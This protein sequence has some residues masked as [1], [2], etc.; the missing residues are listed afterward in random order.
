M[1]G[2]RRRVP[3]GAVIF[4]VMLGLFLGAMESTAVATAMP[5]VIASLG[6]LAI[7]SWVFSGYI[8]AATISMPL[9]GKAADLYGRRAAYLTG[10]GIFLGGSILSGFATSMAMLIGF[11]TLQGLGG[12][13]LIQLG[14]TIIADLYGLERR[15]KMQG[16]FS[17][18]WGIAS[19][20]GP[21]IGG[22]LTDQL[23]WRWVFFVNVPFGLLAA[24]ILGWALAGLGRSAATVAVDVRGVALLTAGMAALLGALVEGGRSGSFGLG[25]VALFVVAAAFLTAFVL[26]ERRAPEPLLPLRLFANR[27]FRAAAVS[28]FLAGMAMFGTISFIPLFVQGVLGGTATEAGT[29]L[30]P[31]VLGWVTLSVISARLLLKVGYRWPVLSG[32]ICLA[33]AF[34]LMSHMGLGTSRSA[35]GRN[36]LLAGMGMGLI[37]VP[38]LIAVQNA[39]PKRDL[40]AATSGTTFFR[41][42]G[43]AVGVA[44]MGAVLSHQLAS[45]LVR[46]GGAADPVSGPQLQ[47]LIAHP[48]AVVHPA[49]RLTLPPG[50]LAAFSQALAN[51]LHAVFLVGFA[52]ACLALVSAFLVPAGRAQDLAL[53]EHRVPGSTS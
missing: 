50:V 28:G 7:Y 40:G 4:G 47:A 48:D 6:G 15:A 14:Y 23:S 32:M 30:T 2:E 1:P 51:A 22:F 33:V 52:I 38:L 29:A 42:I 9:W 41:S 3:R 16:Y 44:L 26:W 24:L 36:M 11:R 12:G 25:H 31:F 46:L 39:V 19:I 10:V 18:T 21:L 43:G 27:M 8:L 53:E 35:T 20:V 37:M 13:A 34:L 5:T 45:Q 17:A 49:L